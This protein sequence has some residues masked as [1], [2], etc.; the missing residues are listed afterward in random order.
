MKS[1]LSD[2]LFKYVLGKVEKFPQVTFT[3]AELGKISSD[4]FEGML[5]DRFLKYQQSDPEQE[6]FPCPTP[7]DKGCDRAIGKIRGSYRAVCPEYSSVKPI[8]LTEG[9]LNRYIFDIDRLLSKI[10]NKN[11]LVGLSPLINERLFFVGEKSI[12]EQRAAVILGLFR[13]GREAESMLLGIGNQISTY[14][15]TVVLLPFFDKT[16]QSVLSRL[17]SQKII[18][19]RFEEAFPKSDFAIDFA[20]LE[21]KRPKVGVEYPVPTQ[22]QQRDKERW[23]YKCEDR[24][25]FTGKK[26]KKRSNLIWLNDKQIKIP[27]NEMLLLL[28]LAIKLKKGKEGWVTSEWLCEKRITDEDIPQRSIGRLRSRLIPG[29]LDGDGEKFIENDGEG[30]YRISTHPDFV[31]FPDKNWPVIEFNKLKDSLGKG[32][33]R[34]EDQKKRWEETYKKPRY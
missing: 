32:R 13:N 7:C 10:R 16:S 25:H 22:E 9:D 23:D 4:G 28:C 20:R 30:Q 14:D 29:L 27:D 34:R 6:T 19:A 17:E 33:E 15:R 2:P 31:T 26:P 1:C 12:G 21:R 18:V 3:E 24:L 8:T 5:K 11:R